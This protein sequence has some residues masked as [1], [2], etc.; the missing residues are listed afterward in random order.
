MR[1]VFILSFLIIALQIGCA[2]SDLQ[3]VAK[4]MLI[5]SQ[6]IGQVQT[7]TIQA[8]AAMLID[9][10][11]TAKILGICQRT[12]VA[13]KQIDSVLRS[14][15]KLDPQS[16]SS[17]VNLLTPISQSL[18]PTQIEFIA[19]IKNPETRQ[20]VEGGFILARTTIS[21]IQIVLA[22]TGGQ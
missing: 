1:K 8:N 18:D 22:G 6:T 3:K 5:V 21:G 19:N 16:R 11:T 7:S 20:Q 2:D 10:P 17:I 13:G 14:I 4:S 12:N 15:A 9:D